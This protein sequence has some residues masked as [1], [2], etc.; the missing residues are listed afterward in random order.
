MN[1]GCK[2]L[3]LF[4]AIGR[5]VGMTKFFCPQ[6]QELRVEAGVANFQL[7]CLFRREEN[8]D[9]ITCNF[10]ALHAVWLERDSQSGTIS[11]F[12]GHLVR[13]IVR[14]SVYVYK[15]GK[16]QKFEGAPLSD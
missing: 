10:N 8:R 4:C 13:P 3:P 16:Y 5:P 1:K 14:M 2:N 12:W 6:W 7:L 11:K 15:L 9:G